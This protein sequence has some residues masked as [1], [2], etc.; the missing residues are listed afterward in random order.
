MVMCSCGNVIELNFS[1]L[2]AGRGGPVFKSEWHH[3]DRVTAALG[4]GVL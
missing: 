3:F 1:F 2:P 4:I